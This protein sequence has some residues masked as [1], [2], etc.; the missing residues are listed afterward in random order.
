LG[1][2]KL[3]FSKHLRLLLHPNGMLLP[4]TF[5]FSI[6]LYRKDYNRK[7]ISGQ[8]GHHTDGIGNPVYSDEDGVFAMIC[9][10]FARNYGNILNTIK[11]LG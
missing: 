4:V 1:E 5:K 8:K 2:N 9:L 10:I 3:L 7:S 11:F 6:L